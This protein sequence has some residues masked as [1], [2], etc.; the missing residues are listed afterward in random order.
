[1]GA[2]ADI[3]AFKLLSGSYTFR[4]GSGG[5]VSASTRLFCEL[6]LAS[7]R[8]VWDWNSRAGVPYRELGPLYGVREGIDSVLPPK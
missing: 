7:G 4:D 2:A 5:S 1:V 3:A 8:V 6:T